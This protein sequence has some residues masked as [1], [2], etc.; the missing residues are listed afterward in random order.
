MSALVN[1]IDDE[2]THRLAQFYSW[3]RVRGGTYLS[4]HD[5]RVFMRALG[6]LTDTHQVYEHDLGVRLV[7]VEDA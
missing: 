6:V 3:H 1:E 5:A 7:L 2:V 4:H